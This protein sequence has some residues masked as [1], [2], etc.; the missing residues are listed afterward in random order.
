ML[1]KTKII[2]EILHYMAM[3]STV[4]TVEYIEKNVDTDDYAIIITDNR[5]P[6]GS[7]ALL[8]ERYK[9]SDRIVVIENDI[10]EGFTRGNNF[11][12]RYIREHYEFDFLVVMNNDVM[13][14]ETCLYNKLTEYMRSFDFAVAGPNIT[15]VFGLPTNPLKYELPERSKLEK[16]LKKGRRLIK[17]YELGLLPV[18]WNIRNIS[19][20]VKSIFRKP[21][22]VKY[23]FNAVTN[24]VLHGSIWFFSNRYFECF[25][26]LPD[27]Q[28]M[29]FEEETLQ[30]VLRNKGLKSLYIPDITVVHLHGQSINTA[31]KNKADKLRLAIKYETVGE[32]IELYDRLEK[33]GKKTQNE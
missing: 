4:M 27:K 17:L 16:G 29:Y 14:I 26:G 9:D 28:Y 7:G 30:L 21:P 22:A 23:E 13:I 5:S 18:Y 11:G 12:I 24:V 33:E 2:F 6:D 31:Y 32:Y 15:D 10:N 8:K 25:D 1:I 3:D 19:D 20:R